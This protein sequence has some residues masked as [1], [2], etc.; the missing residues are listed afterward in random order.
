[1]R[2]IYR[3]RGG[4]RDC[5]SRVGVSHPWSWVHQGTK[6]I[7]GK[8][9][10][11]EPSS[12]SYLASAEI[13]LS[14]FCFFWLRFYLQLRALFS[15]LSLSPPLHLMFLFLWLFPCVAVAAAAD[16]PLRKWEANHLYNTGM[17][18]ILYNTRWSIRTIPV[19][20]I[21][22]RCTISQYHNNTNPNHIAL[23]CTISN[24]TK[25]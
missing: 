18:G 24:H 15:L 10:G 2:S 19:W 16:S 12:A 7:A 14:I 6:S 8:A 11:Q 9:G 3:R 5:M 25:R 17:D 13:F 21:I 4:W 1:M 23:I 22:Q 20:N